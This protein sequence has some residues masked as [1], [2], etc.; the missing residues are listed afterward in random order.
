MPTVLLCCLCLCLA[1]AAVAGAVFVFGRIRRNGDLASLNLTLTMRLEPDAQKSVANIIHRCL[2]DNRLGR[3]ALEEGSGYMTN[4]H[5][6]ITECDFDIFSDRVNEAKITAIQWKLNELPFIP[7]GSRLI[8]RERASEY[9]VGTAEMLAIY[10][11]GHH[12]DIDGLTRKLC[13]ALKNDGLYFFSSWSGETKTALYFYGRNCG[14]MKR[15]VSE[16][17]NSEGPHVK[18]TL[19]QLA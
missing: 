4:A 19:T 7:K 15:T 3:L 11:T 6:E 5:G 12:P 10:L 13:D 8:W 18:Y 14:A 1:C 2:E 9:P 17:L 16:V